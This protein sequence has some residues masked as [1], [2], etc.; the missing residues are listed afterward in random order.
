MVFED[1]CYAEDFGR[2]VANRRGWAERVLTMQKWIGRSEGA[3]VEFKVQ[4]S[5][6]KL[7]GEI[8]VGACFYNSN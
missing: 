5:K 3:F 2:Y 6:S 1:Y 4:S 8:P 7:T